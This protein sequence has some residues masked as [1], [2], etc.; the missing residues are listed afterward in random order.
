MDD[1]IAQIAREENIP[2]I[3]VEQVFKAFKKIANADYEE[4]EEMDEQS[5]VVVLKEWCNEEGG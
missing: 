2:L 1:I 3:V 5:P 4:R